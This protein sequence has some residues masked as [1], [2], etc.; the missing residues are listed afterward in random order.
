M[1]PNKLH[2]LIGIAKPVV[3]LLTTDF[4]EI[5]GSRPFCLPPCG[6]WCN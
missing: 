2:Q 3:K 4:L 5:F 6:R 1:P